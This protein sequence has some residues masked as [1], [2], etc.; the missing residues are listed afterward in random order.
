MTIRRLLTISHVAVVLVFVLV[1]TTVF[2]MLIYKKSGARPGNRDTGLVLSEF[3]QTDRSDSEIKARLMDLGYREDITLT[4]FSSEGEARTILGQ[5]PVQ[6]LPVFASNLANGQQI[7]AMEP[8][9]MVA[10]QWVPL[11][12]E[13][14][15]SHFLKIGN[16]RLPHHVMET[17]VRYFIL[18]CFMSL[19]LVLL[20]AIPGASGIARPIHKL[21]EVADDFGRKSF[22]VRANI[23]G[24]KELHELGKSFNRMADFVEKNTAELRCQKEKAEQIEASR[25]QFLA[26][27]SHNL[28]TPLAAILGWTDA[29]IEGVAEDEVLYRN[30]IRREV[31]HVTRIVQRML[32]LSRWEQAA[33]VLRFEDIPINDILMEVAEN[34]QDVAE[35]KN[36]RLEFEGLDPHLLIK[37]DRQKAR[38]V[39]QILLENVVEHSGPE[40]QA[41]V[42]IERSTDRVE[43]TVADDGVGFP[44]GFLSEIELQ[45]GTND[46]GKVSLGLAI[47]SRLMEAHQGTLDLSIGPEGGARARVDFECAG[48]SG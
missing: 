8:S 6:K 45:R 26:D 43:I 9:G 19:V 39:L 1:L 20:A 35:Q 4:L 10:D 22:E 5:E 40:A 12:L 13:G 41:T 18:A 21:A 14:P 2:T 36:I 31:I 11:S 46:T 28:R 47:A 37:A 44:E 29:L 23:G 32:E 27:V 16:R 48:V 7:I 17:V 34:L 25:R 15:N 38:D 42:S 3:F 30:R 33:P 24:P